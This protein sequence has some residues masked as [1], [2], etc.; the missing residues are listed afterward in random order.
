MTD[1]F[2]RCFKK[3][4]LFL[5]VLVCSFALQAGAEGIQVKNAELIPADNNYQL[6][7]DF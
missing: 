4:N 2:T 6:N 7:A 1:S 5:L 3:F